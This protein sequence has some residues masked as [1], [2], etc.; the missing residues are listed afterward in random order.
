VLYGNLL[1]TSSILVGGPWMSVI[2]LLIIAYY[3]FYWSSLRKSLAGAWLAVAVMLVI[4]FIYVNNMTLML[5]PDRWSEMYRANPSG[6][7]LNLGEPTLVPRYLHMMLGA[8]AIG[9]V[10]VVIMGL[11]KKDDEQ[12]RWIVKH[13]AMWFTVPTVLNMLVGFWF[14]V[15][16]PKDVRMVFF[17][18]SPLASALMGFGMLLP[19]AAVVHLLLAPMGKKTNRQA[20][21]GIFS[22][23]ATVAVMV[24]MR[25]MAR[26]AYLKSH[27]N[28]YQLQVASQWSVIVLFVVLFV[29]GL[30]TVYWMVNKLREAKPEPVESKVMA[31]R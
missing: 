13:G 22:A 25:D 24:G 7:H 28:V 16:M 6:W 15:A 10:L 19:I 3:A 1:Y 14:L 29:G 30:A 12:K 9:G 20:M 18:E 2:G 23:L 21:I 26:T 11:L 31:A 17:G 8:V 4:G 27:F 5:A